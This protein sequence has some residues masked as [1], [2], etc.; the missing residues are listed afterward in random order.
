MTNY[1]NCRKENCDGCETC[2]HYCQL[3]VGYALNRLF[4]EIETYNTNIGELSSSKI[5]GKKDL[6]VSGHL[7]YGQGSPGNLLTQI[8]TTVMSKKSKFNKINNSSLTDILTN[9]YEKTNGDRTELSEL[10][11]RIKQINSN[12]QLIMPFKIGT[13]FRVTAGKIKDRDCTVTQIKWWHS[14]EDYTLYCKM[15]FDTATPPT[16][17]EGIELTEY[18]NKFKLVGIGTKTTNTPETKDIIKLTKDGLIKTIILD[19]GLYKIIVDNAWIYQIISDDK[20]IV[21]GKWGAD[22]LKLNG[23]AVNCV[24]LDRFNANIALIRAHRKYIAPYGLID[25]N[26]VKVTRQKE[27]K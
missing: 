25:C 16:V 10:V 8:S 19:D 5:D 18:M 23:S 9:F 14:N 24:A 21:I 6:I 12:R 11:D 17:C 13:S 3:H 7:E 4:R 27:G 2:G 26:E 20:V 1:F 15:F 22:D